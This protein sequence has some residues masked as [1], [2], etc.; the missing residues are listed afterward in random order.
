ML[1]R[2]VLNESAVR[3]L[4]SNRVLRTI[5]GV[6]LAA[7]SIFGHHMLE[8]FL[9]QPGKTLSRLVTR[10][11]NGRIKHIYNNEEIVRDNIIFDVDFFALNFLRTVSNACLTTGKNLRAEKHLHVSI[12]GIGAGFIPKVLDMSLIDEIVPVSDQQ[13]I[14]TGR[15]LAREEGLLS[16][17]SSGAAIAAALLIGS[18]KEMQNKRE[19]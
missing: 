17:I 9:H 18:R 11:G 1:R 7:K 12:Q 16:G 10:D 4:F 2:T 8:T 15:K 6:L 14:E 13:A 5:P 19:N 3:T